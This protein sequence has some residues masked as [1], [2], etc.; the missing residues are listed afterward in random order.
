MKHFSQEISEKITNMETILGTE[1]L[2]VAAEMYEDAKELDFL[3]SYTSPE[4]KE[5]AEENLK[6]IAAKVE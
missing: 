5:K 3:A 2:K 6:K 4:D 1:G